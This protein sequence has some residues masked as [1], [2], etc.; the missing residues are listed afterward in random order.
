MTPQIPLPALMPTEPDSSWASFFIEARKDVYHLLTIFIVIAPFLI[1]ITPQWA[2]KI[3]KADDVAKEII[4]QLPPPPPMAKLAPL[5][6]ETKIQEAWS[7][8]KDVEKLKL[9]KYLYA[10]TQ[11]EATSQWK[12]LDELYKSFRDE[13]LKLGLNQSLKE[14]RTVTRIEWSKDVPEI[15]PQLLTG[16]LRAKIVDFLARTN[17]ILDRLE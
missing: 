14:I 2:D 12:D 16:L 4:K 17:K 1:Q 5:T 11:V 7:H 10:R 8:N 13:E 3:Q 9:L 6:Y 15:A